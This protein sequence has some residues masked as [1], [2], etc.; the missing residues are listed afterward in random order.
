[1]I[2]R[3]GAGRIGSFLRVDV[4]VVVVVVSSSSLLS[5]SI[6]SWLSSRLLDDETLELDELFAGNGIERG[7]KL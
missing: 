4:I 6:E 3:I 5:L 1:M 2:V 7:M